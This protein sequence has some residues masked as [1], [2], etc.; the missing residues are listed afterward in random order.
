MTPAWRYCVARHPTGACCAG[1][2]HLLE[3]FAPRNDLSP[4]ENNHD[5]CE[6]AAIYGESFLHSARISYDFFHTGSR[7]AVL[8]LMICGCWNF[9]YSLWCHG[10]LP[11]TWPGNLTGA[12][13]LGLVVLGLRSA[14]KL[15]LQTWVQTV[16]PDSDYFKSIRMKV[17]L[18]YKV[19]GKL[20]VGHFLWSCELLLLN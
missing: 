10:D 19:T 15:L 2:F 16:M 6:V 20:W 18:L 13:L 4:R 9:I 5:P 7:G 17:T 14:W 11:C 3:P 8:A 12:G 1:F